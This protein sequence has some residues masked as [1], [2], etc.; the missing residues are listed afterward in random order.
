MPAY[1]QAR[2]TIAASPQQVWAVLSDLTAMGRWSP[3]CKK[4]FVLGG[5]LKVGSKAVN[6][7]GQGWKVWPTTSKVVAL[8]PERKI[9]FRVLENR[10]VWSYE[11]TPVSGGTEVVERREVPDGTS[12]LSST[13]IRHL[14][15]GEQRFEV[16]LVE[17]MNRTLAR[18][19]A[20]VEGSRPAH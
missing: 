15:G 6:V 9:A 12:R 14:L 10:T 20:E 3:Q 19:K 5:P 4:T 1:L 8:E 16:E 13:L 11:L 17:G 2:T 7:N 18:L